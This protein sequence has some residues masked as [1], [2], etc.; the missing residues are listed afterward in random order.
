MT[1]LQTL[2]E[3]R[4]PNHAY[5]AAILYNIAATIGPI[6]HNDCA[7]IQVFQLFANIGMPVLVLDHSDI[8]EQLRLPR[9][10][11]YF[12]VLPFTGTANNLNKILANIGARDVAL[13]IVSMAQRQID[14]IQS[15]KIK[16]SINNNIF[17]FNQSSSDLFSLKR[18]FDLQSVKFETI[19][20]HQQSLTNA[21]NR[22]ANITVFVRFMPPTSTIVPSAAH[23][24][25]LINLNGYVLDCLLKQL[26][27]RAS[28]STNAYESVFLNFYD[29][30]TRYHEIQ[31]Y[32]NE[33]YTRTALSHFNSR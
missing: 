29:N 11:E 15:L 9:N 1:V 23:S 17:L 24:Y 5:Y 18:S 26:N 14:L 3:Q 19:W 13:I 31:P 33:V 25:I 21:V 16:G 4:Q 22:D 30:Y 28:L 32:Y 8:A 27:A 2:A 7:T 6:D 10:E 20:R 12:H